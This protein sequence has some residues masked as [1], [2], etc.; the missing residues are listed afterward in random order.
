MA[1]IKY[2]ARTGGRGSNMGVDLLSMRKSRKQMTCLSL[3]LPSQQSTF[4]FVS[5]LRPSFR[6]VRHSKRLALTSS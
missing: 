2:C 1:N 4:E 6:A 3:V 5:S